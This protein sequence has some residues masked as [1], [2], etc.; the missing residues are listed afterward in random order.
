MQTLMIFDLFLKW[1]KMEFGHFKK[2]WQT[3]IAENA[4]LS[5]FDTYLSCG[6]NVKFGGS[7][8]VL[9]DSIHT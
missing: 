4:F 8:A 1:Q 7:T 6:K 9:Q 5:F 3:S 2:N